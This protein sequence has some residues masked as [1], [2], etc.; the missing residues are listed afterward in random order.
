MHP[1]MRN[2]REMGCLWMCEKRLPFV[3]NTGRI[4]II[5]SSL[6]LIITFYFEIKFAGILKETD[7]KFPVC[8]EAFSGGIVDQKCSDETLL[9]N[10]VDEND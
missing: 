5:F 9:I 10:N 8:L 1:A 6:V 7:L 2:N 4:M 3:A